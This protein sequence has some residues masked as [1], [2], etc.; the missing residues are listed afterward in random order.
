MKILVVTNSCSEEM[1]KKVCDLRTGKIVDPQQKFFRLLID[2]L[3][4]V[5]G[6][7]VEVMSALPVSASTVKQYV[8]GAK[9]EKTVIGAHYHYISFL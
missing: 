2:G 9:E 8:F 7:D 3:A 6:I 5:K 1:Y 4:S